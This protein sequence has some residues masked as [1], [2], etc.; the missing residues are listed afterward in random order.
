MPVTKPE[1]NF[2]KRPWRAFHHAN[3]FKINAKFTF[4]RA[5]ISIKIRCG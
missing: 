2:S 4:G 1:Q 3:A 5:K